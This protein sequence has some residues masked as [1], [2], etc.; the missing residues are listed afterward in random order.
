MYSLMPRVLTPQPVNM[1]P[2]SGAYNENPQ[3]P[4]HIYSKYLFIY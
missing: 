3:I 2:T 4:T 1:V